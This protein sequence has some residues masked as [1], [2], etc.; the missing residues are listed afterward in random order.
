MQALG[1][2][3]VVTMDAMVT[4]RAIAQQSVAATMLVIDDASIVRALTRLLRRDGRAVQAA[5]Q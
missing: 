2:G 4:Q 5:G 1:A 3:R